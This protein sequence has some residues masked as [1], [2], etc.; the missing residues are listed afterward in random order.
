MK[1]KRTYTRSTGQFKKKK[2]PYDVSGSPFNSFV[3]QVRVALGD[4]MNPEMFLH[5]QRNTLRDLW[6]LIQ[7]E[8]KDTVEL[9]TKQS[10][11]NSWKFVQ[12]WEKWLRR[13][14]CQQ[15]ATDVLPP[16]PERYKSAHTHFFQMYVQRRKEKKESWKGIPGGHFIFFQEEDQGTSFLKNLTLDWKGLHPDEKRYYTTMAEKDLQRYNQELKLYKEMLIDFVSP[17]S[18]ETSKQFISML[19]S[20]KPKYATLNI[21]D[22]QIEHRGS[23]NT[24]KKQL[25]AKVGKGE[26]LL[27]THLAGVIKES[28]VEGEYQ[29]PQVVKPKE[30]VVKPVVKK[31]K[32]KKFEPYEGKLETADDIMVPQ[33]LTQ[34]SSAST[35]V[36]TPRQ[37]RRERQDAEEEDSKMLE[38]SQESIWQGKINLGDT[39]EA[40]LNPVDDEDVVCLN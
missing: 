4:E 23:Q 11:K 2:A 15:Y 1:A 19:K 3:K 20:N 39:I 31:V 40:Q 33:G 14:F 9:F 8:G 30:R 21:Y 12:A 36:A 17:S 26:D 32:E 10:Q 37:R 7:A 25:L 16:L 13:R 38:D 27:L 35:A 24:L 22:S 28:G 34:T 18:D 6:A 5:K 29:A